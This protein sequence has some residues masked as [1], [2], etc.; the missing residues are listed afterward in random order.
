MYNPLSDRLSY[1]VRPDPPWGDRQSRGVLRHLFYIHRAPARPPTR[2]SGAFGRQPLPKDLFLRG[3]DLNPLSCPPA[4]LRPDMP[5][6]D[7][8]SVSTPDPGLGFS[9]RTPAPPSPVVLAS[10]SPSPSR[11]E[12]GTP[13]LLSAPAITW[14]VGTPVTIPGRPPSVVPARGTS[15]PGSWDGRDPGRGSRPGRR[16]ATPWT[17]GRPQLTHPDFSGAGRLGVKIEV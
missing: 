16:S 3:E 4:S 7:I 5:V 15:G 13:L 8:V 6:A 14:R 10:I 1:R 9:P 11:P 12:G 17:T 2:V